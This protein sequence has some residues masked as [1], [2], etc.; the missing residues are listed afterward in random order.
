MGSWKPPS[1]IGLVTSAAQDGEVSRGAHM[2]MESQKG[3]YNR[4]VK[5]MCRI[6]VCSEN[7]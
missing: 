1:E 6:H 4:A 2:P 3:I 7:I 5:L